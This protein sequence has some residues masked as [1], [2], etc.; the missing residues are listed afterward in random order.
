MIPPLRADAEAIA[1]DQHAD[2]QL[3]IDRRQS[4]RTVEGR[5][6][7]ASAGTWFV[8][9]LRWREGDSNRWSLP[10]RRRLFR[11]APSRSPGPQTDLLRRERD[12][13]FESCFLQER[14]GGGAPLVRRTGSG[15]AL[16]ACLRHDQDCKLRRS[17]LGSVGA[18]SN[19]IAGSVGLGTAGPE[20]RL[21][22]GKKP[23]DHRAPG[24]IQALGF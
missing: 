7:L 12:R 21:P 23:R 4:R 24:N 14:V 8:A 13:G 9:T 22:S 15:A 20:H 19:T 17:P 3:R 6:A 16:S 1:H 5:P 11:I 2:Q 10:N 18:A